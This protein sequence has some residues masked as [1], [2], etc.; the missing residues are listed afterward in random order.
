MRFADVWLQDEVQCASFVQ[1]RME[2]APTTDRV[3]QWTGLRTMCTACAL[4]VLILGYGPEAASQASP[5]RVAEELRA[6]AGGSATCPIPNA[7]E[8]S[9]LMGARVEHAITIGG[10]CAFNYAGT[11]DH[12]AVL[13]ISRM[14]G[15]GPGGARPDEYQELR[16]IGDAAWIGRGYGNS[17]TA[18]ARRGDRF[19]HINV[20]GTSGSREVAIAVLRAALAKI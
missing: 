9:A 16:G 11:A 6:A 19:V 20:G 5:G 14:P 13:E 10:G 7:L 1:S 12:A 3:G 17:W 4:A 2:N 15:F 8:L 18:R